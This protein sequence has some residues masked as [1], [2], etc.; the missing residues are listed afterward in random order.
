MGN[1][2]AALRFG[3]LTVSDRSAA[4]KRADLSGPALQQAILSEG[5]QV[6]WMEVLPDEQDQL[7]KF[8]AAR[9]RAG[10]VDVLLT[11]GGTGFGIRDVTPE[12]SMQVIDRPAPGIAEAIRQESLKVTPH[13]MLARNAAGIAGRTLLVNLSGSP[14]AAR[15]QFAV[16]APVLPH[17]VDLLR[18]DP[19]AEAGHG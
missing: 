12:A 13:A 2:P 9:S 11:T 7:V 8:L 10:D 17:A 3:I 1:E 14:K 18:D 5:W 4:G 15:E 19:H 16:I 6:I